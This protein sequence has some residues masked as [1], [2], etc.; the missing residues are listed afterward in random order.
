MYVSA[1]PRAFLRRLAV[2][3][4]RTAS[5]AETWCVFDNTAAGAALDDARALAALCS[6]AKSS[7][8]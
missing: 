2:T 4:R 1:Y 6:G 5:R 8:P 3:L 7:R